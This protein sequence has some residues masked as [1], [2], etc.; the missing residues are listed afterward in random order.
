MNE[1]HWEM[2]T[3]EALRRKQAELED[4]QRTYDEYISSSAELENELEHSLQVAESSA[5]AA[6]KAKAVLQSRIEEMEVD[7]E[8]MK[9]ELSNLKH[10]YRITKTK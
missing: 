8:C 7:A 3:E 6:N 10:S 5:V 2:S 4:L 1:A 9:D